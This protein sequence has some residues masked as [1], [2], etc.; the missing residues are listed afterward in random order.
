MARIRKPTSQS[1]TFIDNYLMWSDKRLKNKRE[2]DRTLGEVRGG[3]AATGLRFTA[4]KAEQRLKEGSLNAATKEKLTRD[5]NTAQMMLSQ[6]IITDQPTTI[7][8]ISNQFEG[9]LKDAVGRTVDDGGA[10]PGTAWY[11]DQ[12]RR[13]ERE[14]EPSANLTP[15]QITAMGGKLSAGKTPED[16]TASLGGISRLVS[17]ESG[18]LVGGRTVSAIPSSELADLASNAS[19]WNAYDEDVKR[20]SSKARQPATPRPGIEDE[21]LSS[22]LV[23]AGRAHKANVSQSLDIARGNV[24]PEESFNVHTTPKTA[25]YAEMQ[26]QSNPDS[27]V[28][29]DYRNVSAH[30]RDVMTGKVSKDQGM[31]M[32]SQED[33]GERAYPLRSDAPTAIDTWM[34]A[35]G[36][37]QP[38]TAQRTD[39]RGR[40]TK[41]LYRPAKRM[42]DKGFPLD[43]TGYG[44]R[45]LGLEGTDPSVTPEAVVSAQ[46]NEA[47]RRLSENKIGAISFDQFGKDVFTPSSL[48]QETVWTEMRKQSDADVDFNKQ[49]R[50][51]KPPT[52][53]QIKKEKKNIIETEGEHVQ[54]S[55]FP[56]L[57]PEVNQ[58][59]DKPKKRK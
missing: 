20:G 5:K 12:R 41:K 43:P 28:E 22:A 57:V 56:D 21:D 17:T 55:L 32:F 58:F 54:G 26:A 25:A 31:M 18:K 35:A 15:R 42:V 9:L 29:V 45:R 3:N 36:S 37:G 19:A 8:H 27:Q 50:E 23:K 10:I 46:H 44:K 30:L 52:D 33:S 1:G 53:R 6:N 48:I 38:R 51:I 34:I 39:K 7:G 47:I 24:T 14:V 11:F 2:L 16:E 40:L 4:E 49:Q 59:G 13:Q